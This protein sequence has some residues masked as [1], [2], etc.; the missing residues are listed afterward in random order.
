M[1][2]SNTTKN[3]EHQ[4]SFVLFISPVISCNEGEIDPNPCTGAGLSVFAKTEVNVVIPAGIS[5]DLSKTKLLSGFAEFPVQ[6]AAFPKVEKL[7]RF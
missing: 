5:I 6:K 1:V 4:I 7:V 3:E 2:L